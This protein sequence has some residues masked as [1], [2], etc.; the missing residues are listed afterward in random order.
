MDSLRS[1]SDSLESLAA[2]SLPR[3]FHVPSALGGRTALGFD[4]RRLLVPAMEAEEGEEVEILAPGGT[5]I[6][7]RV[8]GFDPVL[9][10]AVLG[11]PEARPESAWVPSPGLPGLASL[12]LALAWPS[13]DGP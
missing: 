12:V 9:G 5:K 6:V 4:G 2:Q 3:L 10:L 1:F 13:P 8:L 7:S 11:L